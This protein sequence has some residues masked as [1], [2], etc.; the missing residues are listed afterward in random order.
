[1]T[2]KPLQLSCSRCAVVSSSGH[3]LNTS[4]GPEIDSY[5]CIFR[6]NNAPTKGFEKDV[7]VRTTVRSMGHVNLIKGFAN[8]S[9]YREEM[10]ADNRTRTDI[11][12]INWMNMMKVDVES[13]QDFR[14]ALL[15][16]HLYP[17]VRFFHFTPEKT[18]QTQELF[19]NETGIYSYEANTWLS[20]GWF[21]MVAAMDICDEITVFGM[22]YDDYCQQNGTAEQ[23]I[24]YHYY[25]P[26]KLK[27]CQYYDKSETRL[28]G[29]HLFITE[30]A[31][32]ENWAVQKKKISFRYPEWPL[33][34]HTSN[35]D[36]PFLHKFWAFI[37]EG[38]NMTELQVRKKKI[39]PKKVLRKQAPPKTELIDNAKKKVVI[40]TL[41]KGNEKIKV[42]Q[43][44]LVDILVELLPDVKLIQ[45]DEYVEKGG[46][47]NK[48]DMKKRGKKS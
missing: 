27:E 46:D 15:L 3:L 14:Y 1:M 2:Y 30:K 35:L 48:R 16:A 18:N 43:D 25:E 23:N 8:S 34:N 42:N 17:H 47:K 40:M 33:A 21:T 22:A 24:P 28:T 7:G 12:L 9:E 39:P 37:K 45:T 36:T 44:D 38:G 11:V 26:D 4:A 19:K 6:M 31:V 41:Q 10:F 5:P 20:T 29:G 13:D 32:F